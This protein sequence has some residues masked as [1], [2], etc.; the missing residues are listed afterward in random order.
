MS[1]PR[2]CNPSLPL[3]ECARCPRRTAADRFVIDAS[4][5][6][7]KRCP[8]RAIERQRRVGARVMP[9]GEAA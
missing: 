8:V 7:A 1:T 9:A 2:R 5:L 4:T 6:G 3:R